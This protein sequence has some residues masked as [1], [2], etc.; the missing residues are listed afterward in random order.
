MK[1]TMDKKTYLEITYQ[2]KKRFNA[3]I[4]PTIRC[5]W[6]GHKSRFLP[7]FS[8]LICTDIGICER[9]GLIDKISLNR[10]F[11]ASPFR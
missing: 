5:I 2:I 4:K 6:F 7:L 9:C 1:K 3:K 11:F 8:E 10:H